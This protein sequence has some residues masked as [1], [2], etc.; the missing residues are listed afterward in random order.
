MNGS[1]IKSCKGFSLVE[2]MIGIAI[3][4]VVIGL[5]IPAYKEFIQ[6][7]LIR[8]TAESILN[9]LQLAKAEAVKRNAQV[10]FTLG[11]NAAWTVGCYVVVGD[12]NGD[13]KT[14]CPAII[15]SYSKSEES[16][17]IT[18]KATPA[19]ASSVIFSSL[20][21]IVT[22]ANTFNY[23]SVDADPD[24]LSSEKSNDLR[25]ALGSGGNVKMCDPNVTESNDSRKCE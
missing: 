1:F 14:D 6:N 16:S 3:F 25:I 21:T 7:T 20:G 11:T 8:S 4:S 12:N 5:G 13:G 15:Q 17:S 19:T 2:L 24:K 10:I 9:G 23:I 18:V 22:N